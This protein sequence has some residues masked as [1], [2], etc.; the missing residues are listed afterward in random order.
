METPDNPYWLPYFVAGRDAPATPL[1]LLVPFPSL[2]HIP[3]IAVVDFAIP[4]HVGMYVFE[5]L[6]CCMS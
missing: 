5:D 1:S 2:C 3:S 6:A 4:Y